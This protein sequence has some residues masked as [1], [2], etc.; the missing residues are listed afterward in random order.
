[1]DGQTAQSAQRHQNYT[2][3]LGLWYYL[4]YTYNFD[5]LTTLKMNTVRA[6]L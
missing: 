6:P 4:G 2:I 5:L 1:M 3:Y